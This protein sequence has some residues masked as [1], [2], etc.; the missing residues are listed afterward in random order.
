[1]VSEAWMT[2]DE[3]AD[4][5]RLSVRT[6]QDYA[7]DA[8][9]PAAERR[10][11]VGFPVAKRHGRALAYRRTEVIAYRNE[12]DARRAFRASRIKVAA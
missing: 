5:L 7:L 11:P 2:S 12:R 4:A 3:V 1:M 8:K 10:A 9:R 6:V